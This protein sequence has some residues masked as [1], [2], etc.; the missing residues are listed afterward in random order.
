MKG[1][2]NWQTMA[3]SE[4][5]AYYNEWRV[6]QKYL[7]FNSFTND[8]W[9]DSKRKPDYY[10]LIDYYFPKYFARMFYEL[11]HSPSFVT[12]GKWLGV[13]NAKKK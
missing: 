11:F 3:L 1:D 6:A 8:S 9:S 7:N 4:G 13:F 2:D 12:W 10:D 5:W